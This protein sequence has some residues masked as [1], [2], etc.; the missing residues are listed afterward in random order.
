MDFEWDDDK[1]VRNLAKHGVSFPEAATVFGDPL[2]LTFPDPDHSEGEDRFPTFGHSGEDASSSPR[3][4]TVRTRP[5]SSALGGRRTRKGRLMTK[6]H[7]TPDQDLRPE[8]DAAELKGGV[9]GK[10]LDR[11]RAG[12]NLALL[13]PNVRAAFPTDQAVNRALRS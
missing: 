1:A 13:A 3:A 4:P 12:T 11:Y 2:A 5:V 9:R 6:D 8:Y 7:A 10:H